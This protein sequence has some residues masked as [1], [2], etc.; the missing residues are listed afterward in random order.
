MIF[1][2]PD[3]YVLEV[4]EIKISNDLKPW[5][6]VRAFLYVCWNRLLRRGGDLRIVFLSSVE[7]V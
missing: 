7:K 4:K 2:L 6:I 5:Q 1:K 3:L